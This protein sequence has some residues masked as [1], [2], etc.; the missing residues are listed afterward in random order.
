MAPQ[1]SEALVSEA[2]PISELRKSPKVSEGLRSL[3]DLD[4]ARDAD[5]PVLISCDVRRP[6]TSSDVLRV[7]GRAQPVVFLDALRLA[8][9]HRSRLEP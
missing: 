2:S 3:S 8:L 9:R 6:A 7:C 4:R 5:A 1:L